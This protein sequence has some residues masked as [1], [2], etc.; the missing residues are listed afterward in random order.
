[1]KFWPIGLALGIDGFLAI[2]HV[3]NAVPVPPLQRPSYLL[4]LGLE[5]NL[6]TWWA[7][8]QLWTASL[9]LAQVASRSA[10]GIGLWLGSALLAFLSLDETT[11]LHERLAVATRSGLLP[12]TGLWP[13]LLAP[14]LLV[15][16]GAVAVVGRGTLSLDRVASALLGGGLTLLVASAAGVE[17]LANVVTLGSVED[18]L[19]VL[20]E[21][22][23]ELIAGTLL[24]AGSYRL[25]ARKPRSVSRVRCG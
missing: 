7:S 17:L 23:G 18:T 5:A 13:L 8:I 10:D 25:A 6:P 20:A 1:M 12:V 11:S 4:D 21:E 14:A 2:L 9:L 19:Q 15:A 16:A 3:A 24:L 22:T